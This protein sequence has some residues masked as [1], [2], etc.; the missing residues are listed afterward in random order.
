MHTFIYNIHIIL[1]S[2]IYIY[3][4]I[5]MHWASKGVA[6]IPDTKRQATG[7]MAVIP[8]HIMRSV[9]GT[10]S[11]KRVRKNQQRFGI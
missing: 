11:A 9:G 1:D 4:R 8:A 10:L 2:I 7:I 3:T 6:W 5:N